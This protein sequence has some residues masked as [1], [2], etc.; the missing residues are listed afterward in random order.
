MKHMSLTPRWGP[1][2]DRLWLERDI[3]YAL[4]RMLSDLSSWGGSDKSGG[5]W[6]SWEFPT[7]LRRR[8]AILAATDGGYRL[9]ES[10]EWMRG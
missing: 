3:P 9:T 5:N 6:V 10:H 7:E 4:E 8:R 2:G 1:Y